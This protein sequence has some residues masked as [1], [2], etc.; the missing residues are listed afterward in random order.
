VFDPRIYRVALVPALAALVLVMFSFQPVPNPLQEPVA[1]PEFEAAQTAR[2]ARQIVARAPERTPGSAGDRTIAADVRDEFGKVEGGEVAVQDF[3]SEFR[4]SSVDLQNVVLTIPGESE[5]TILVIAGRDSADG[6]GAGTSAAATAELLTLADTLGSQRHHD[7]IIFAS[8]DGA[9]DGAAGAR[10]LI[11]SLPRPGDID[12]AIVLSQSGVEKPEPPFVITSGT[13]AESP[14]AQLVQT[15]RSIASNAFGQRDT[16]PGAWVDLSRLA[17]PAGLGEQA[18]L[19]GAGIES[20][21]LSA[22]GER[23]IDPAADRNVS[24]TTIAQAGGAALDLILTLD[25][26]TTA[27]DHGPSDYI[28]IGDNLIPGWT[29]A[30]LALT[31]LIAPL[32]TA[33]DSWL[34]EQRA[35][36]RVRRT[37]PWALERA[38]MP[39]AALLLAYL[40]SFVGLIPSPEFP[41]DPAGFPAG[42]RGPI[43]FVA[44]AA[45]FALAGLLIRPMRTPLDSQ[46][47]V[48]AAAGGMICGLALIGLWLLN[49]YL[50]L[51]LVPAAHVW[52]LPA[53]IA[54]PPRWIVVAGAAVLS[55]AGAVAA[56]V[57]VAV[58]LDLGL[59]APWHLLLMVVDGQ[60]GFGVC[61]L[62][63]ALIGGLIACI[64]ATAAKRIELPSSAPRLRGAGTHVGP[65]ALGSTPAADSRHR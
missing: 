48:L 31:L 58:Q 50:A 18:V 41:F 15:A 9:S 40:L 1:N 39:L 3:T 29:I 60:I 26:G 62:W 46:A 14:N 61:M 53:R 63:C 34:R 21:T 42:A 10:E 33:T 23:T 22:H 27:P 35:D 37:M 17:F 55:L 7:T 49:P 65:G 64:S 25:E 51:L 19:R 47:H 38:L 13:A 24:S 52:M 59:S 16:P 20:L 12:A 6:P 11:D 56:F 43:S 36:W 2:A 4:D 32:L 30:L 57:T 54:G 5:R 45:A 8:T 44:L 28:R